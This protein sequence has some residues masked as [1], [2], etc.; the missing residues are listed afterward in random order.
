MKK[1]LLALFALTLLAAFTAPSYAADF[2]MTGL[3]QVRGSSNNVNADGNDDADDKDNFLEAL[4]R[5][6]FTAKSGAVTAVWEPEFGPNP[7]IGFASGSRQ[8]VGVNRWAIDF[9]IP[10]SALRMRWGRWDRFSPDKEIFDSSGSHRHPG[11]GIYGKLSKNVSLSMFH[12]KAEEDAGS[13]NADKTNYYAGVG[14][15]VAPNLTLSPWA[16][17]SRHGADNSYN[18]SYLGL[19]AKTK[20]GIFN[21]NASGVFQSGELDDSTDL[22]GWALL[23]RTSTSL[24]KL[25]LMG[26]L[27]MLSGD[28]GGDPKKSNKFTFPHNNTSGW[29]M[30]SHIMSSK[31]WDSIHNDLK[32]TTLVGA[33]RS[34][35]PAHS[36]NGAVVV[37]GVGEYKLS[38]TFTL[39]GGVSIYN[40]AESST[41]A[42]T[43][44]AKDFGTEFNAGFKWKI[45]S[46][47]ELRAVGAVLLRG[48]YGKAKDAE[49]P[50]DGWAVS[51]RLRHTF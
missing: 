7:H 48:D 25:K 50:D 2:K 42:N 19:H 31:R 44:D 13:D 45:H 43:D 1:L 10:G 16:A 40:S 46:N 5:P 36:F 11:V 21:M 47:L 9:A 15:K 35:N 24:G 39:G 38:K 4:I 33:A 14:I 23:V 18:Y 26:N 37:E 34:K 41:V 51:W 3:Y 49:T 27:T 29:L 20:M 6:R 32:N 8:N 12:T 17:N 30:G 28:D 22:S